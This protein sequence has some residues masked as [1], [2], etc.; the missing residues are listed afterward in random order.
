[1]LRR[2]TTRARSATIAA[3]VAA[4]EPALARLQASWLTVHVGKTCLLVTNL[5]IAYA[6]GGVMALGFFGAAR[7]L[8]PT[9]LSPFAGLPTARWP[10][11]RVLTAATAIRMLA[12][13]LIFASVV[14]PLPAPV[15]FLGVALESGA[16]SLS[17]PLHVALLPFVA[18]TPSGLVAAN[19]TSS[20]VESAGAFVGPALAG[21]LLA[22]AGPAASLAAVAIVYALGVVALLG[23]LVRVPPARSGGIDAIRDQALAGLRTIRDGRGPRLILTGIFLQTFVRG[24]LNVLIVIAAVGVLGLGNGGVG[25]LSALLGAGG[26]LGAGVA[27]SLAGRDRM[28]VGFALS[29]A[30]WSAPLAVLGLLPLPFVAI[31]AMLL[32][33][34]A[35][36]V[37]DVTAYTLLQRTTPRDRRVGVLGLFD[38]L[39]NGG[40]A[41]GGIIAPILVAT[42]G[43]QGALVV[44]GL[45]L[46]IAAI[47]LWPG[48]RA[49]DPGALRGDRRFDLV[50][51]I[52]LFGPLSLAAVEDVASQ[53]RPVVFAQGEFLIRQGEPGLEY[54]I[55]DMGEIEV[56]QDGRVLRTLGPGSGV[57]EIALL[58]DVPRTASVQALGTVKAFGLAGEDFRQAVLTGPALGS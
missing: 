1:M 50:R 52:P 31:A 44:A 22:T 38:S 39:A 35:N 58:H 13:G 47:L 46:P 11:T 36:A 32:I 3:R 29:L 14:G 10:T 42:T 26:L 24:M 49:S 54:F 40:Q 20:A 30:A 53:L 6:A 34:T 19:A 2:L 8:V 43:I 37:V 9:I 18:R 33:G 27:M 57:G 12:V 5:V 48:L 4:A 16:G 25:N 7:F 21:L 17:R 45:V 15:F 41:T 55:I 56:T 28:A 51:A 23:T